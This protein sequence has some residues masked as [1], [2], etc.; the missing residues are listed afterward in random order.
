MRGLEKLSNVN[1]E[2]LIKYIE[3]LQSGKSFLKIY[4]EYLKD[5]SAGEERIPED[6]EKFNKFKNQIRRSVQRFDEELVFK[7][8]YWNTYSQADE[9]RENLLHSIIHKINET[10]SVKMSIITNNIT[11]LSL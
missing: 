11:N 2:I 3:L 6:K 8:L 4:Q 7:F 1:E 5:G 10:D 9:E